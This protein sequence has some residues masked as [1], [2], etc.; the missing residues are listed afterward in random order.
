[1]ASDRPVRC[2]NRG[3]LFLK[4]RLRGLHTEG[5]LRRVRMAVRILVIRDDAAPLGGIDAGGDEQFVCR[6]V[7]RST[8]VR[9]A[10][11]VAADVI[12]VAATGDAERATDLLVWLRAQAFTAPTIAML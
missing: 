8:F 2:A 12:V 9:S 1:M 4:A 7:D 10:A 5:P 6:V 11:G 3:R